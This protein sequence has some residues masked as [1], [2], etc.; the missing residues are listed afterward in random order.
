MNQREKIQ[1]LTQEN[2]L[3]AIARIKEE[4]VLYIN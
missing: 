2:V 3:K 4:G 1:H